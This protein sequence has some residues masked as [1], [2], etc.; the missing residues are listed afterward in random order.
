MW[1]TWAL[2]QMSHGACST[3]ARVVVIWARQVQVA[4]RRSKARHSLVQG[5]GAAAGRRLRPLQLQVAMVARAAR[6]CPGLLMLSRLWSK[7]EQVNRA[8]GA[9]GVWSQRLGCVGEICFLESV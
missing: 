5:S 2:G 1:M 3:R 7:R 6:G 9:F 4:R 8:E